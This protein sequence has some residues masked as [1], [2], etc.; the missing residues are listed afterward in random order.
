MSDC[1]CD[2]GSLTSSHSFFEPAPGIRPVGVRVFLSI[3]CGGGAYRNW[4]V[5]VFSRKGF[6]RNTGCKKWFC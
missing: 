1:Y 2:F 5:F 3:E 6:G 4:L